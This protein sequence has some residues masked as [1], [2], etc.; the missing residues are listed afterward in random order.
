M[1]LLGIVT[2]HISGSTRTTSKKT[3]Q[4]E[5]L[6]AVNI[7]K[8]DDADPSLEGP[9]PARNEIS[10][11]PSK[12]RVLDAVVLSTRPG[13]DHR[14]GHAHHQALLHALQVRKTEHSGVNLDV[15]DRLHHTQENSESEHI[16]RIGGSPFMVTGLREAA[17]DQSRFRKACWTWLYYPSSI[18]SFPILPPIAGTGVNTTASLPES[19]TQPGRSRT[20]HAEH[21]QRS[22]LTEGI[23][24]GPRPALL[25]AGTPQ[26]GFQSLPRRHGSRRRLAHCPHR[27]VPG[28][29]LAFPHS[30][31][32]S[33]VGFATVNAP[34]PLPPFI[35]P[36]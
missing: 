20:N 6:S 9:F 26:A 4:W 2:V 1:T 28:Q 11:N 17:H 27:T 18:Q 19:P 22:P 13:G 34:Q 31:H 33:Y 12:Y 21:P 5:K 23:S 8:P 7:I 14:L 25:D 29:S 36:R 15:S 32:E 3:S 24:D 35:P 16:W 30:D 10:T